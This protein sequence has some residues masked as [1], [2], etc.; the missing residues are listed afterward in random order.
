LRVVVGVAA[1]TKLVEV[2]QVDLERQ[3]DYLSRRERHTQ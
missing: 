1:Q 2:A 3:R